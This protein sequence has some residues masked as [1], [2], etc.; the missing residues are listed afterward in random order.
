MTVAASV[1]PI[2]FVS[3]PSERQLRDIV[4]ELYGCHYVLRNFG[5][6]SEELFVTVTFVLNMSP[7]GHHVCVLVRR[8]STE[9]VFVLHPVP[10]EW[11]SEICAAWTRF[12]ERELPSSSE[13]ELDQIVQ[14]SQS[15]RRAVEMAR[16]LVMKGLLGG[17]DPELN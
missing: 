10:A 3:L 11:E 12:I 5:L 13:A 6:R 15:R 14:A 1:P 2:E 4:S 16:V 8:G 7:P 9:A 17:L